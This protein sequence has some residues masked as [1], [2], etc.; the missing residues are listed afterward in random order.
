MRLH[1]T[2]APG[3]GARKPDFS[4]L[5]SESI[6]QVLNEGRVATAAIVAVWQKRTRAG[7][8]SLRRG[9]RPGC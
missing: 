1:V 8:Q 9:I 3:S 6:S 4:Q 5:R 7:D 2:F